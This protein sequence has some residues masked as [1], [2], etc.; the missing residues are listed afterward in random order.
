MSDPLGE[1]LP[2]GLT[3]DEFHAWVQQQ[4]SGRYELRAGEIVMQSAERVR[5]A[6][7]KTNVFIALRDGIRAAGLPCAAVPDGATLRVDRHTAYEP[8]ALVTCAP[9]DLDSVE[10]A[11]PVIVVEVLSP[12]SRGIDRGAKLGDYFALASVQHYLIIDPEHR[13]VIHHARR[14]AD[15]LDTA[16]VREGVLTLDPPGIAVPLAGL[17]P[18]G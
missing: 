3:V 16:I 6:L 12:G 15:R 14:S 4:P 18:E 7:V 5:H 2:R 17:W 9:L 10:V 11:D 8:D 1:P 13:L